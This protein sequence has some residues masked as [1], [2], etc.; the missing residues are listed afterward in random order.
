[1]FPFKARP[2]LPGWTACMQGVAGLHLAHVECR[3]GVRPA[4]C[5]VHEEAG[6]GTAASLRRARRTL[7]LQR[8]RCVALLGR[9][10]YQMLPM[11]APADIPRQEW[12]DA[13]R[14]RLK[15]MVDFPVEG[16][17]LALL[18]VAAETS[19]RSQDMLI[20]VAAPAQAVQALVQQGDESGIDWQAIDVPETALRNL[21]A[22]FATPGRG[23]ALL[24]V[25]D[26]HATLV[27][28]VGGELLLSR[29]IDLTRAQ[30][31]DPDDTVR[32]QAFDRAGLELQRTLDGFERMHSRVPLEKLQ[33]LA[34]PGI[35]AF[36]D[37]V[38]EIVYVPVLEADA[39]EVLELSRVPALQEGAAL[40][41]Y[42]LVIGA[43]LRT[44]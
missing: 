14:W 39:R 31:A 23:H 25:G 19:G 7:A 32:Q 9:V 30:L 12:R 13:I 42:L 43:A 44:D 21:G 4:V 36:C 33:M 11:D 1:M 3:S 29:Q 35:E 20:A 27:I 38:R 41:D 5:W 16:A 34:G 15:D 40:A 26:S 22:L 2:L 18:E 10:Q 17:A 8:R 28:T 24:H 37:Y 6:P